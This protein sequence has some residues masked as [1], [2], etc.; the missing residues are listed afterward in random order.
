M[1]WARSDS[2]AG[3]IRGENFVVWG[4]PWWRGGLVKEGA[5]VSGYVWEFGGVRSCWL[6]EVVCGVM[7][8][9]NC[10]SHHRDQVG[11]R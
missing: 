5:V 2:K 6:V 11:A 4:D 8:V 3:E 7:M 10:R 9:D 1:S